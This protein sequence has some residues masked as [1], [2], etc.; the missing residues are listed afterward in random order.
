M[1][2]MLGLSSVALAVGLLIYPSHAQTAGCALNGVLL[3]CSSR[4]NSSQA[5]MEAFASVKT[6]EILSNPLA[7][8]ERF[9]QNGDL[10]RFR[11]S[12]E[13]NWK[14]IIRLARQ[15]DSRKKGGRLSENDFQKWVADFKEAEKSYTVAISFY[16]ELHWKGVN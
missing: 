14:K 1:K 3:D 2:F 11:S 10:E 9:S 7:E 13:K 6:R 15:Q 8:R 16:R 12:M 5:V 4:G